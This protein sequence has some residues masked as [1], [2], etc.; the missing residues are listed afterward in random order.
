MMSIDFRVFLGFVMFSGGFFE[1]FS[2]Y[3]FLWVFR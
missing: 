2:G 1:W 3:L